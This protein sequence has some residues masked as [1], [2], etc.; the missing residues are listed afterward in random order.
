MALVLGTDGTNCIQWWI[1]A[2]FVVHLNMHGHTTATMSLESGSMYSGSWKQELVSRSL[3]ESEVIR[4][5]DAL[6]QMLWMKMFLEAQGVGIK[7]SSLKPNKPLCLMYL[8]PI[9]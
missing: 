5:Y 4:V 6:P 1:N 8:I 9:F 7:K 3:T 2:Y